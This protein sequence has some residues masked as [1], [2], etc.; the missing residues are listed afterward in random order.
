MGAVSD[1][2]AVAVASGGAITVLASSVKAWL[3]QRRSAY[4]IQETLGGDTVEVRGKLRGG[5]DVAEIMEK[6]AALLRDSDGK[7]LQAVPQ[8]V[9]L[10]VGQISSA[11][12]IT[13]SEAR[14][15]AD[16]LV[17]LRFIEEIKEGD[18][19]ARYRKI[20]DNGVTGGSA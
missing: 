9:A 6:L 17:A 10:D 1:V 15:S 19:P 7:V 13:P 20:L 16:R 5:S 2:L 18:E 14:E 11:A 3:M 4:R 12:Q 8:G